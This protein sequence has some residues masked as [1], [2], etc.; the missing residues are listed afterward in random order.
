MRPLTLPPRRPHERSS[1]HLLDLPHVRSKWRPL[2]LQVDE[3]RLHA[4]NAKLPR[5]NEIIPIDLSARDPLKG[6]ESLVACLQQE[7]RSTQEGGVR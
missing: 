2:E 3:R 6:E 4:T 7:D 1:W 5:P